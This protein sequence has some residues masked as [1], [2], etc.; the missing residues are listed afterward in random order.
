MAI[1]RNPTQ[2]LV[3]VVEQAIKVWGATAGLE[4]LSFVG[5]NHNKHQLPQQEALR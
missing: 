2:A 3:A 4:L 5:L 1:P